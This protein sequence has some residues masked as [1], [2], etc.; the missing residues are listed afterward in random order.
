MQ[1]RLDACLR[2][3]VWKRAVEVV[4]L[5]RTEYQGWPGSERGARKTRNSRKAFAKPERFSF[6]VAC[7]FHLT[8]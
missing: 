2:N 1:Q 6:Y 5:T 4:R 8:G 7:E 3:L